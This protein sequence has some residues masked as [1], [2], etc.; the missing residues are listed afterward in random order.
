MVDDVIT[1]TSEDGPA[2]LPESPSTCDYQRCVLFL[3]YLQ[4]GLPWLT[5]TG[6]KLPVNLYVKSYIQNDFC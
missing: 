6:T 5:T 3:R 2:D 4:Y 1:D